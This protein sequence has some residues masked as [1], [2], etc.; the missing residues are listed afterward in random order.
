MSSHPWGRRALLATVGAAGAVAF[1]VS[2][3][4]AHHC[5]IPMY[6][7]NGPAS[8]NWEVFTA[9]DGAAILA[10]Y[11]AEC[12]AA[13]EAGYAALRAINGPVAIKISNKHVIGEGSNNPNRANG[14]GLEDFEQGST[15]A[16]EMV[17]VW[18]AAAMATDCG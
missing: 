15:L 9:Q 18:I 10:G 7:F 1:G 3:A 12:D 17:Q 11:E 14:V 5:Y 8:A 16:G 13:V 4:S 6:S 2:S